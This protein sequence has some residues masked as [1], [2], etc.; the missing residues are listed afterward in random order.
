MHNKVVMLALSSAGLYANTKTWFPPFKDWF[1][2]IRKDESN[3]P[4]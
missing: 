3:H 4:N 2:K 1:G